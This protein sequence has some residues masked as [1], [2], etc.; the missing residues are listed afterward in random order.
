MDIK[1]ISELFSNNTQTLKK[2][3]NN[4]ESIDFSSVLSDAINKVNDDQLHADEMDELLAAGKID[5]IHEVTIAAQKAELSLTFAIE[6]KNKV[7]DA[8]NEIMRLQI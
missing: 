3:G 7:M 1:S 2:I 5:N 4:K 6:V 8:Y